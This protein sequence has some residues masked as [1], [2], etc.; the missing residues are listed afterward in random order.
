MRL[1]SLPKKEKLK[2]NSEHKMTSCQI[3]T[4]LFLFGGLYS[5]VFGYIALSNIKN[6]QFVLLIILSSRP[7]YFICILAYKA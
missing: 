6:A 3:G 5:I 4:K 7:G 2:L 1:G